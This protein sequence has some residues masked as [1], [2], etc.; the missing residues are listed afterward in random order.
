MADLDP[1][2]V[3][4]Y[5]KENAGLY[6]ALVITG[7]EPTLDAGLPEFLSHVKALDLFTG[8]ETNGSNPAMVAKLIEQDLV[9][10]IAVDVKAPLEWEAYSRAAGLTPGKEGLLANVKR[11]L[12]HLKTAR[13]QL[14]LRCTVVPGIHTP[15]DVLRLAG[16]L[17]GYANFVLQ[18]FSAQKTLDPLL[19]DRKPFDA[20]VFEELYRQIDPLFPH[21]EVR[22]I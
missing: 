16:Q 5:L 6:Q 18:Q 4:Q 8:V 22:G 2:I 20:E 17:R 13:V 1:N 19:Q 7:G 21:C 9:D 11:T 14:E 12:E 3:L 10:Y 15:E